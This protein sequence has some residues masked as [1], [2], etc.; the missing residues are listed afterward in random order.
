[1]SD[2]NKRRLMGL[3][4]AGVLLAGMTGCQYYPPTLRHEE[5]DLDLSDPQLPVSVHLSGDFS[6]AEPT[7][8]DGTADLSGI[9]GRLGGAAY[10]DQSAVYKASLTF[11]YDGEALAKLGVPEEQLMLVFFNRE[12]KDAYPMKDM[13]LDTGAD[14]VTSEVWE[15]GYY[16][17]VDARNWSAD[18]TQSQTQE[19]TQN[20]G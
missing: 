8:R 4:A 3:A 10:L 13:Q 2:R 9:S 1:M 7:F 15:L 6:D 18:G 5:R 16:V 19:V 20:E 11:H 12:Q 17:L 14:T